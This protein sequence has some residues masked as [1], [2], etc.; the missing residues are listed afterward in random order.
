MLKINYADTRKWH[1]KY[2]KLNYNP[3]LIFNDFESKFDLLFS[4]SFFLM[5]MASEILLNQPVKKNI[6]IIHNNFLYK[7][8]NKEMKEL[9]ST[10]LVSVF[11]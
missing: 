10:H 1:K 3:K 2:K 4:F 6:K 5:I 9:K 7:L 11:F 8:F